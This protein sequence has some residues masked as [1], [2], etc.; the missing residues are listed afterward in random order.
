MNYTLKTVRQW[1]KK[2]R[3]TQINEKIF[4][5][6]GINIVN[7]LLLLKC[8]FYPRPSTGSVQPLSKF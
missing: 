8:P 5:V 2:L 4:H 6:H 3:K 7:N 1:G